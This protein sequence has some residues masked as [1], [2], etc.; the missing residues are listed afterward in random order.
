MPWCPKCKNEYRDGFTVCS[1]CGSE[2][3]ES[4]ENNFVAIYFGAENELKEICAFMNSNGIHETKVV[5][6]ETENT[7][8]LL[9]VRNKNSEAQKQLRVY[10]TQIAAPRKLEEAKR[11]ANLNQIEEAETETY[12]TPYQEADKKAEEYKSGADT[13][14]IV[15][16]LGIIVL[17]LLNFDIIPIS[18]TGFSKALVT[19]VLGVMFIIFFVMGITS[20]KSYKAL[21]SQ[22]V[23]EKEQKAELQ[24]YLKEN[25]QIKVFDKDLT[26]DK[27]T[28]EILY[29]RRIEKMKEMIIE[30]YP[31]LDSAFIDY[32]IEEN[33]T[34]IFE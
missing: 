27:P 2:L 32:V 20:R 5:F 22:A 11:I 30:K 15:G 19:G 13:L 4:L 9:V 10:L 25:I 28:M 17:I 29:F 1:D 16:L 31:S 26:E 21:K 3:V 23:N 18:L 8:E 34:E 14:L 24:T 33:Y 7:Y 6:D 12:D